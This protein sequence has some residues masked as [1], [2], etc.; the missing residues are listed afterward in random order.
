MKAKR[1][2]ET[3]NP[4]SSKVAFLGASVAIAVLA[5]FEERFLG[6]AIM[7]LSSP[8][9]TFGEFQEILPALIGGDA[10]FDS[11]HNSNVSKKGD[12]A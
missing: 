1:I 4:K 8:A 6:S 9:E 2:V 5:S 7:A 11:R 10:A 12:Y 3:R